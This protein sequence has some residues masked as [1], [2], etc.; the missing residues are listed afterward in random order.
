MHHQIQLHEDQQF[1]RLGQMLGTYWDE[2]SLDKLFAQDD[3][4]RLRELEKE[5]GL[6][7]WLGTKKKSKDISLPL[8]IVIQPNLTE[9]LKKGYSNRHG[10]NA[11]GWAVDA[12][13]E[14]QLADVFSWKPEEFVRFV[15]SVVA[16][17]APRAD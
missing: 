13:K 5:E 2:D 11:P 12:S 6:P 7:S 9:A 14:G 15:K 1:K 8:S 4:D 10:I 3:D 17:V 16:P